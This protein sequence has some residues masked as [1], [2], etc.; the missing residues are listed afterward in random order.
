MRCSEQAPRSRHL[1][2]TT[3]AFPLT[4]RCRAHSACR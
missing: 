2:Q 1:R 4:G 3:T